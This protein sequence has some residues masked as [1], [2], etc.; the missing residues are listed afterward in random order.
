MLYYVC[1]FSCHNS[2]LTLL[3]SYLSLKIQSETNIFKVI[4]YNFIKTIK[5]EPTFGKSST[6]DQSS[7]SN[8]KEHLARCK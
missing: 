6:C 1:F 3:F 7:L 8:K 2:N 4:S 5:S